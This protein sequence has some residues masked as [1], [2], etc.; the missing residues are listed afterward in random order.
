MRT[1]RLPL[2]ISLRILLA[3]VMAIAA[4]IAYEANWMHQ[5]RAFLSQERA[6]QEAA[7]SG[8]ESSP[9]K[10][11]WIDWWQMRQESNALAPGLLWL[12][13]ESAIRELRVLIPDSDIH[14]Q[15]AAQEPSLIICADQ[16][17]FRRACRLFPEAEV[18]PIKMDDYVPT[19]QGRAH[20][21]IYVQGENRVRGI[22]GGSSG[23]PFKYDQANKLHLRGCTRRP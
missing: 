21:V 10:Q 6:R 18:V 13:G 23:P 7:W 3:M 2:S 15:E 17:D 9:Y 8:H 1:R 4:F 5:R 22:R 14:R 12:F 11:Q 19:D 20:F 16:R